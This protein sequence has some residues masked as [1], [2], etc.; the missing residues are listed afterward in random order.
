MIKKLASGATVLEMGRGTLFTGNITTEENPSEAIAIAFTNDP[1]RK[2]LSEF[3]PNDVIMQID[4]MQGAAAILSAVFRL[5]QTW[6]EVRGSEHELVFQDM[7]AT[8]E[9]LLPVAAGSIEK[10][11]IK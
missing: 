9:P 7:L 4:T 1:G 5:M 10:E 6:E 3:G 11:V 8:L 2:K